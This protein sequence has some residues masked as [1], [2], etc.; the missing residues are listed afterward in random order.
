MTT[1]NYGKVKAREKVC[2][3][4]ESDR[5]KCQIREPL[6]LHALASHKGILQRDHAKAQQFSEKDLVFVNGNV[7]GRVVMVQRSSVIVKTGRAPARPYH[8]SQVTKRT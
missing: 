4:A 3:L 1:L 5:H 8:Y 6:S 2:G 7:P